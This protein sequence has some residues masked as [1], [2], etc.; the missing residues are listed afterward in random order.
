MSSVTSPKVVLINPPP[1]KRVERHDRPDYPHLG[2]AYIATYLKSK[3]IDCTVIDGK[4]ESINSQELNN[5]LEFLRPDIVG[6]TAMTHEIQRAA[7]IACTIKEIHHEILTIIGGPHVTALPEKTLLEFPS[8]DIAVFGEGEFTMLEIVD[9]WKDNT[10]IEQIMGIAY[11][12]NNAVLVNSP[13]E[14]IDNL[15]EL[16]YPDWDLLPRSEHYPIITGRGCPFRCNFCMRIMGNKERK[17]SVMNV[18]DEVKKCI[19]KHQPTYIH[20]LDETFT[21]NKNYLN[22]LLDLMIDAEFEKVITWDAQTRADLVDLNLLVKMKTAGCEWLGFGIESGNVGILKASGK[23]ITLDRAKEAIAIARKAE[24]KTDAFFIIGHPYET[25]STALDTINF[26]RQLNSTRATFGIM[27]PYPGTK[28]HDMAVNGEGYYKIISNQWHDFGKNIG[29]SVELDTLSRREL[30][31]L[32]MLAYLKFYFHNLRI[33]PGIRY[34]IYQRGLALVILK[35]FFSGFFRRSIPPESKEDLSRGWGEQLVP[36]KPIP[37]FILQGSISRYNWIAQSVKNRK[38]LDVACGSGYGSNY[39][40]KMGASDITGL[41][42]SH[43]AINYAMNRYSGDNIQFICHDAQ[44]LPFSDNSFDLVVSFETIEHIE[45][46]EVFVSECN[47]VLRDGGLFVCSTPNSETASSNSGDPLA[48]Y[49]V[50]EFTIQEFRELMEQDFHKVTV[51]G[52]DP[53][54]SANKF[55]YRVAVKLQHLVFSIPKMHLIVNFVTRFVFR[56]Y[57]LM[58]LSDYGDD[59]GQFANTEYEPYLLTQN[60]PTPGDIIAISIKNSNNT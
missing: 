32:Q 44:H 6:I 10:P 55:V 34:I 3:G 12:D 53:Q 24:I 49:H 50:K 35:K 57:R 18:F 21:T 15:D 37:Y 27:V 1:K 20:F 54:T 2:L 4:F 14:F 23:N 25:R 60:T 17:R 28:I 56:R 42:V 39:L 13:R 22:Q 26:A 41:D 7:D 58:R 8:F 30:E 16:P 9:A 5:K 59:F 47:R 43:N 19:E 33:I 46:Y 40:F 36:D 48:H 52:M 31:K 29:N 45:H 38:I 51:Y 11:R